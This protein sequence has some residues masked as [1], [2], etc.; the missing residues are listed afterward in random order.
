MNVSRL[1]FEVKENEYFYNL[2][3]ISPR[4]SSVIANVPKLMPLIPVGEPRVTKGTINRSIFC[5]ASECKPV[6]SHVISLQNYIT[7]P[8]HKHEYPD[9]S[10]DVDRLD[11]NIN[12]YHKFILNVLHG[13]IRKMYLSTK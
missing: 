8:R 3:V 10:A 2:V 5:N 6:P 12:R 7:I 1:S 11:G 4:P 13:D 9:Y